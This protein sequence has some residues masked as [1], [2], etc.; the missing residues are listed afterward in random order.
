MYNAIMCKRVLGWRGALEIY[1]KIV[2]VHA[3]Y[4][5]GEITTG[6]PTVDFPPK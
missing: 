6:P 2:L 3:L 1:K 4:N 5:Y